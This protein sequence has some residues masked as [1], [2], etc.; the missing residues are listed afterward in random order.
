[1]DVVD[2]MKE[3]MRDVFADEFGQIDF[4]RGRGVSKTKQV[5]LFMK[6]LHT[7]ARQRESAIFSTQELHDVRIHLRAHSSSRARL[8]LT[9]YAV[10][11]SLKQSAL[12]STGSRISSTR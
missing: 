3:S 4:R 12:E 8:Q 11:R 6:A 9:R 2:I 10:R 1:M 5:T 7:K